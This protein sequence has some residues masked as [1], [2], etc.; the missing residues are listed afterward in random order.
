MDIVM[1]LLLLSFVHVPLSSY[2]ACLITKIVNS[3]GVSKEFITFLTIHSTEMMGLF[4]VAMLLFI[5]SFLL[6]IYLLCIL[7][8]NNFPYFV[9]FVRK[10]TCFY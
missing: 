9:S 5:F 6:S 1:I 10:S 8:I 7:F 4:C 2:P 3:S